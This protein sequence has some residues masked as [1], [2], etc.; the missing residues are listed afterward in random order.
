MTNLLL[1]LTLLSQDE[2]AD[3]AAAANRLSDAKSYAFKGETLTETTGS[4][5]DREKQPASRFDGKVDRAVGTTIVTDQYEYVRIGRT[6]AAR[7]RAEWRVVQETQPGERRG[8]RLGG[9]FGQRGLPRAPHEELAD[10]GSKILKCRKLD[11]GFEAEL[12]FEAAKE[13]SGAGRMIDRMGG[14][15]TGR[16]RLWVKDG[17]VV[18]YEITTSLSADVQGNVF[19][20]TQTRTVTISGVDE[21]KV[22]IPEEARKAIEKTLKQD[23]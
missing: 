8:G 14:D 18:R 1:A 11:D 20:M 15:L 10:F 22:E 4:G 13:F 23:Y 17:A 21:T 12:T 19:E 2:K 7:P 5:G 9:F 6:T 16:A 3:A